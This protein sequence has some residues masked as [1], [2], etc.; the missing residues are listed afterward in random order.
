MSHAE[1]DRVAALRF[2]RYLSNLPDERLRKQDA[3][4]TA[5]DLGIDP[6][7]VATL[8]GSSPALIEDEGE[9][10]VFTTPGKE[11]YRENFAAFMSRSE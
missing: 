8:R 11:W 2:L 5:R 4:R 6:S 1:M 10:L 9:W 3:E 7:I